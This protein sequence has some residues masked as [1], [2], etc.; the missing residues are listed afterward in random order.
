M[1][2]RRVFAVR[3]HADVRAGGVAA[4]GDGMDESL[5]GVSGVDK[6]TRE[7]DYSRMSVIHTLWDRALC[8]TLN[9]AQL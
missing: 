2:Y 8:V 9:K 3:N 7:Y 4:T 1:V 6:E 5:D